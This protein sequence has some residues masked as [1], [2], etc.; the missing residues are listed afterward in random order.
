MWRD[1]RAAL[2]SQPTADIA[3]RDVE[4]LVRNPMRV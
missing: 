4:Q 1:G 2:Q 3:S